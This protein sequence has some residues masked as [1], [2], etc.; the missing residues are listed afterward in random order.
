MMA[1]MMKLPVNG[2]SSGFTSKLHSGG[3]KKYCTAS[4]DNT[5]ARQPGPVPIQ[6]APTTAA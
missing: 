6:A 5:T 3:V 2:T 4:T 1:Q